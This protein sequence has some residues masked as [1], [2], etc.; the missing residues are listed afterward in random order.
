[1]NLIIN[2]EFFV[3][4]DGALFII[5][6]LLIFIYFINFYSSWEYLQKMNK[7]WLIIYNYLT[8]LI[9]QDTLIVIIWHIHELNS[10]NADVSIVWLKTNKAKIS[11]WHFVSRLIMMIFIWLFRRSIRLS[12]FTFLWCCTS[13]FRALNWKFV[14]FSLLYVSNLSITS[15]QQHYEDNWNQD[16]NINIGHY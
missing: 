14:L 13:D 8:R 4:N 2:F 11:N 15:Y 6:Q 7:D 16:S 10:Q 1:M 12:S 3:L 9:I 5:K